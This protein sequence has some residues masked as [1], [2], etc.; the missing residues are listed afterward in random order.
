[1][2]LLLG[3]HFCFFFFLSVPGI[4]LRTLYL[5]GKH[6]TP[7]TYLL[8][9]GLHFCTCVCYTLRFAEAGH[10]HTL[11]SC[12]LAPWLTRASRSLLN[13]AQAW[14]LEMT[15]DKALASLL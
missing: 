6:L 4:E 9:P 15:L 10:T 12:I 13:T 1:M 7:L 3:L 5:P 2:S 11:W 14:A 8:G